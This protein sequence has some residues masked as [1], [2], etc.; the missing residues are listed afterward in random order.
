MKPTPKSRKSVTPTVRRAPERRSTGNT[1]ATAA[2]QERVD[3]AKVPPGTPSAPAWESALELNDDQSKRLVDYLLKWYEDRQDEQGRIVVAGSTG[4]QAQVSQQSA[5]ASE[6]LNITATQAGMFFHKRRRYQRYFD[7]DVSD[8]VEPKTIYEHS[9]LTASLAERVTRQMIGK[10][11][12]KFFAT[13]PWMAAV[14]EGDQDEERA[15]KIG[16]YIEH[17][18]RQARLKEVIHEAID[19]AMVKNEAVLKTTYTEQT[20]RFHAIKSIAVDD[21]GAPIFDS[22]GQYI[23]QSAAWDAVEG[24]DPM[25]NQPVI[26]WVLRRDPSIVRLAQPVYDRRRI[27]LE[28]V[29]YRGPKTEL[30]YFEDFMTNLVSR[31]LESASVCVHV[32]DLPAMAVARQFLVGRPDVGQTMEK[33]VA[34]VDR[35]ADTIRDSIG[36][37]RGVFESAANQ[38]DA[39]RGENTT[40][41]G[42]DSPTMAIG[43]F[44]AHYD[45]NEDGDEESI[46]AVV[47]LRTRKLIFC[48]YDC[49]VTATGCR[50]FTC[51]R[52]LPVSGRW[53]GK[54]AME[55]LWNEQKGTDLFLNRWSFATSEAGSVTFFRPENVV[56]CDEEP[57]L[58]LNAGGYYKLKEGK[59]AAETLE[60]VYLSNQEKTSEM[61]QMI[62]FFQQLMQLKSGTVMAGDEAVSDMNASSLATGIR[63]MERAGDDL[64]ASWMPEMAKGIEET[65][66]Q[67]AMTALANVDRHETFQ[68]FEGSDRELLEITPEDVAD[69]TLNCRLLLS[70][71]EGDRLLAQWQFATGVVQFFYGLPPEVQQRVSPMAIQALRLVDVKNA[72]KVIVPMMPA[73]PTAPVIEGYGPQSTAAGQPGQAQETLPTPPDVL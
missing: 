38:P 59:T 63:N 27:V 54:G 70:R 20:K 51:L 53:Y 43:E 14:P 50:A 34:D 29:L 9:N 44:W 23:F 56:E 39:S 17:K 30:V 61:V 68:L 40:A 62:Q 57:D 18:A 49:N 2:V 33:R 37:D 32:Y 60:R 15:R 65:L 3:A 26:Q 12:N 52:P 1:S 8:R 28:K 58:Q 47:N 48:D 72:D 66:T 31:D 69:V 36:S 35:A 67:F 10:A 13:D 42:S 24:V 25:T 11:K 71:T 64:F 73:A 55:F 5:A 41:P 16:K 7:G 22:E 19:A 46:V 21:K 6:A 45:A 4:A